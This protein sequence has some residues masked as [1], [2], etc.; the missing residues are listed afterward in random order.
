MTSQL[1]DRDV[2]GDG[3]LL[4]EDD[5]DVRESVTAVLTEEGFEVT[6]AFHGEDA[7]RYLRSA[8]SRPRLILLDLM[9]PV[10][11]GWAFR[12]AQ[13]EDPA[14]ADIPVVILS[15]T[16]D[17]RQHARQ[18]QV[19]DYLVKPLDVPLLLNTIERHL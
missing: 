4:V 12:T 14:L 17:V 3:L 5:D 19:E 9:M 10:M 6:T 16:T 2:G 1:R 8:P 18:L 11:D 15:A 13:L 7:L